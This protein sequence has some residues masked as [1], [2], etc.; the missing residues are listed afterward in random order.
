MALED[1]TQYLDLLLE[2][3]D[4]QANGKGRSSYSDAIITISHYKTACDDLD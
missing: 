2:T 1:S 3:D 4:G